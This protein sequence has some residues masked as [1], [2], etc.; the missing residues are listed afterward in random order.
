MI[1]SDRRVIQGDKSTISFV[2]RLILLETRFL[3]VVPRYTGEEE[4]AQPM[5]LLV[6]FS[7]HFFFLLP[8]PRPSP[9]FARRP[10]GRTFEATRPVASGLAWPPTEY[11]SSGN[12]PK[13]MPGFNIPANMDIFGF[14]AK[15][16]RPSLLFLRFSLTSSR[17]ETHHHPPDIF[18]HLSWSFVSFPSLS[19]PFALVYVSRSLL[20]FYRS[21]PWS[22]WNKVPYSKRIGCNFLFQHVIGF[23]L[24][25]QRL[26]FVIEI[27]DMVTWA[28]N[29]WQIN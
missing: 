6:I 19:A 15:R 25:E 26:C 13:L 29:K 2:A 17:R 23:N 3:D 14:A 22:R 12:R 18:I 28:D 1:K 20:P 16:Q 9:F 27:V 7:P 8:S 10:N 4:A 21:E 11:R 5:G 24:F